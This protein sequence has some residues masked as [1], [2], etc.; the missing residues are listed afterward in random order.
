MTTT[1]YYSKREASVTRGRFI[2]RSF[3][4]GAEVL[5]AEEPLPYAA[6]MKLVAAIQSSHR[7]MVQIV[8]TYATNFLLILNNSVV[9]AT[10]RLEAGEND[11]P[12]SVSVPFPLIFG[13]NEEE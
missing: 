12:L 10:T 6:G 2:A 9:V 7:S 3:A 4:E 1:N 13:R 11:V 8:Q 5:A